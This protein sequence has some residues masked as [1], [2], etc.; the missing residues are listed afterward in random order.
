MCTFG[1]CTVSL[2]PRCTLA[3]EPQRCAINTARVGAVEAVNATQSTQIAEVRAANTFQSTQ[4][5]TLRSQ[6]TAINANIAGIQA[7]VG[8]LFDLRNGDRRDMRQGVATAIAMG[9]AA[10]PSQPGRVSYAVNGARFRGEHAVGGSMMD[11]LN[12]ASPI[13]FGG[14]FSYAGKKNNGIRVGVAGEF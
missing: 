12:T 13:A 2:H 9:H 8:S 14:G 3:R 10:M 7:D 6:V 1:S 4:I 11:R 5:G